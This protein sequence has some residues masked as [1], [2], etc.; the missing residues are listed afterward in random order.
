MFTRH[1][2][3]LVTA[4]ALLIAAAGCVRVPDPI[5]GDAVTDAF[6]K[7]HIGRIVFSDAQIGRDHPDLGRIRD[8]FK[9][10]EHIYARYYLPGPIA[11]HYAQFVTG[12]QELAREIQVKFLVDGQP[13]N[14]WGYREDLD[15]KSRVNATR[16][17]WLNPAEGSDPEMKKEN[18]ADSMRWIRFVKKLSPGRHV[19][20]LEIFTEAGSAKSEGPA[21]TGEFTF[22]RTKEPIKSGMSFDKIERGMDDLVLEKAALDAIQAHAKADGWKERFERVRIVDKDW[23]IERNEITGIILRRVISVS[24]YARW[25]DDHC[26]AQTFSLAQQHDGTNYSQTL[27][28]YGTGEQRDVDCD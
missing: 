23:S 17:I 16:Q 14:D 8:T 3:G 15:D 28:F 22:E 6:H 25:P 7:A 27:Q 20:R 13:S 10:G 11:N 5:V 12:D 1:T 26:T 21:A 2:K 24:A 19:V 9:D 4:A 18:L